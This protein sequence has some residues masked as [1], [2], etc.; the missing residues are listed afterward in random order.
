MGAIIDVSSAHLSLS[1]GSRRLVRVSFYRVRVNKN[2]SPI[3]KK[4]Y[5]KPYLPVV[6]RKPFVT[7]RM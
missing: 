6:A 1:F 4:I 3:L 7:Q 5:L 2:A